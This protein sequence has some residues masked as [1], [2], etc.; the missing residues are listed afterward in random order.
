MQKMTQQP[1]WQIT[2]EV[3]ADWDSPAQRHLTQKVL[4]HNQ[5]QDKLTKHTCE[6]LSICLHKSTQISKIPQKLWDTYKN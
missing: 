1:K 5:S 4:W 6:K 3:A 2:Q